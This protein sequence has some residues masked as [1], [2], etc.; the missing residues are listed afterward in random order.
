MCEPSADLQA[1]VDRLA[2]LSD[3]EYAAVVARSDAAFAAGEAAPDPL[4]AYPLHLHRP[5]GDGIPEDRP[6][7]AR[8]Q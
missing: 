5:T 7:D 4:V 1:A 6:D 8:G 2:A 3:E